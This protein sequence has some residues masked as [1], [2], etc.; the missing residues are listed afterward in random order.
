MFDMNYWLR[1]MCQ[2]KIEAHCRHG[3]PCE[4][5]RVA[6]KTRRIEFSTGPF[7]EEVRSHHVCTD[8]LDAYQRA[9]THFR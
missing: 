9:A 1:G 8:C 7:Q 2:A 3:V 6:S 5:C 4:I